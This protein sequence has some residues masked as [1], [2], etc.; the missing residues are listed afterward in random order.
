M[1]SQT[2]NTNKNIKMID[3]IEDFMT[4]FTRK[5]IDIFMVKWNILSSSELSNVI[6]ECLE[7]IQEE[8]EM[9][10]EYIEEEETQDKVESMEDRIDELR[11]QQKLLQQVIDI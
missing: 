7:Q 10:E 6:T 5:E 8:I 9:I 3:A 11:A 1:H 4:C 2:N